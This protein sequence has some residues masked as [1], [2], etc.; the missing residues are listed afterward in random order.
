MNLEQLLQVGVHTGDLA[1]VDSHFSEI[2]IGD[3]SGM[4]H[5][6]A[7][8]V[9]LANVADLEASL[10]PTYKLH[11][12]PSAIIKPFQKNLAFAKYLRNKVVG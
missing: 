1:I 10:R 8:L 5:L 9:A 2:G 7:A 6:K 12:E 4:I 3:P 11:A